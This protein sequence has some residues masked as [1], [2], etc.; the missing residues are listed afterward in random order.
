MEGESLEA[1]VRRAERMRVLEAVKGNPGATRAFVARATNLSAAVCCALLEELTKSRHLERLGGPSRG[2][3]RP[4]PHYRF[5]ESRCHALCAQL[6]FENRQLGLTLTMVDLLGR[7]VRQRAVAGLTDVTYAQLEQL[8]REACARCG[9]I[10]ALGVGVPGIVNKRGG[11]DTCD[12]G[13]L[14]L[15]PLAERLSQALALPAVVENDLNAIAYG[16]YRGGACQRDSSVAVVGLIKGLGQGCGIVAGGKIL[17]GHTN[18]AGEISYLPFL[19][20]PDRAAA[21]MRTR[22]DALELAVNTVLTVA[23]VLDPQAIVLTGQALRED[24]MG[25]IH[26]RCKR[27]I[28]PGHLPAIRFLADPGPSFTTG[29]SCLTVAMLAQDGL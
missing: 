7:P 12:I 15:C 3:G 28:P 13:D 1:A 26:L 6:S 14:A 8:L 20:G 29:L 24:M 19:G 11:L 4:T 16:L 22:K 9:D 2:A 18:Y 5:N 10:R 21:M 23:A 27:A 25:E 17:R